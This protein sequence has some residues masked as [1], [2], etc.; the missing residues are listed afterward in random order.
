MCRVVG[1]CFGQGMAISFVGE[2]TVCG[3]LRG[4]V[5]SICSGMFGFEGLTL[6]CWLSMLVA[7]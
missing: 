1:L 3:S 2:R 6:W 7:D 4:G 5:V